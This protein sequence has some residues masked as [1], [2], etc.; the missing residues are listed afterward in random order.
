MKK[1]FL[2]ITIIFLYNLSYCQEI[3]FIALTAKG[4]I[5]LTRGTKILTV[6]PGEKIYDND[7]IRLNKNTYLDLVYKDG[8]TLELKKVGTYDYKNL[9]SILNSNKSSTTK[10]FTKYVLAQFVQ[11]VDDIGNMKVTGSVERLIK[12]PIDYC[13]PSNTDIYEDIATFSWYPTLKKSYIFSIVDNA[14]KVIF[15]KQLNDTSISINFK[16]NKLTRG[17]NYKWFLTEAGKNKSLTDTS[18]FYWLPQSKATLIKDSVNIL[19]KDFRNIDNS[20]KQTLLASFYNNH[21]LYIDM[22]AAYEKAIHYSPKDITYKKLYIQ[23]L[24][25]V[26]LKRKAEA[27][28]KQL[29]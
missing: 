29:N 19:M 2:L 26:G 4:K 10:K 7:K 8:R 21:K 16:K 5:T 22:L 20:L 24:N 15:S 28:F 1:L 12:F 17:D 25:N 11:S 27:L 23:A 3:K 14:G 18:H 13:T 6:K 9:V